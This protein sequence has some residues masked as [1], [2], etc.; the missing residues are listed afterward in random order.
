MDR[1]AQDTDVSKM[2]CL[3]SIPP[4]RSS[5]EENSPSKQNVE[6]DLVSSFLYRIDWNTR[7]W[8]IL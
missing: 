8:Q 6:V 7:I 4:L 2:D 5:G 3:P 1:L